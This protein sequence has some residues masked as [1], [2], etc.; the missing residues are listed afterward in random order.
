VV[1]VIEIVLQD[2]DLE[3]Q[4]I[5]IAGPSTLGWDRL[6]IPEDGQGLPESLEIDVGE[7]FLQWKALLCKLLKAK[8]GVEKF[9]KVLTYPLF[10]FRIVKIETYIY[11]K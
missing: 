8:R 6:R 3:H 5:F 9:S 2:E 7:A 10:V 4:N 11:S 1:L